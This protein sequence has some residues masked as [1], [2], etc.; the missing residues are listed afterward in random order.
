MSGVA[1]ALSGNSGPKDFILWEGFSEQEAKFWPFKMT[2][3]LEVMV[4]YIKVKL[5]P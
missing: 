2:E 3:S 5:N 1:G 4:P